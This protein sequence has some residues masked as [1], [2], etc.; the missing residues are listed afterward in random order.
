MLARAVNPHQGCR[1]EN[2]PHEDVRFLNSYS[3][4]CWRTI[5]LWPISV[6][7]YQANQ[8]SM[9]REPR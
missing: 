2:R 1:T 5:S 4:G 3:H 8:Y 7:D 6:I 9:E